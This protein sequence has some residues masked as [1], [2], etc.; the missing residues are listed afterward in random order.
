MKKI[1][2][3]LVFITASLALYSFVSSE[4]TT[5]DPMYGW[6]ISK[7][8]WKEIPQ[9]AD[10]PI[11]KEKV[12]LGAMLFFDPRL[13]NSNTMSCATCHD[14]NKGY[15][16]GI[17]FFKG[18]HGIMG[19]RRTPTII[20]LAWNSTFFW[21]GR[22]ESLEE[23]SLMPISADGEMRQD[24]VALKKELEEAGYVPY[25]KKAFGSKAVINN[26]YIARA[27]AAFERTLVSHNSPFDR[28]MSGDKKALTEAQIRGKKIFETKAECTTCHSGPNFTDGSFH[29]LGIDTQDEGRFKHVPVAVNKFAFKTPGLRDIEHRAP[30]FHNGSAKTL[31]EVMEIY[32]RGG[33][34]SSVTQGNV[35]IKPLGLTD[36][37]MDDVVE[38]MKG[39][40]GKGAHALKSPKLPGI[41]H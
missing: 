3:I 25:F 23:Q 38:F 40:S 1:A 17:P 12:D 11:T 30:Y 24:M 32:N 7:I 16:D 14:P 18:D 19:P 20:N 6:A 9:P 26:D 41:K 5:K 28:Y 39:L 33:D 31:R 27:I 13:S 34:A 22:A 8:S 37:E 15:S 10:N 36:Q 4:D 21:D 29:N 35:E 2:L